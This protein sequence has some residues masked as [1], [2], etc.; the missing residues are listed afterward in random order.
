MLQDSNVSSNVL[1]LIMASWSQGA[2]KQYYTY[3]KRRMDFCI[4]NKVSATDASVEQAIEFLTGLCEKD[5]RFLSYKY[6]KIHVVSDLE[7]CRW[8]DYWKSSPE[9][10]VHEWSFQVKISIAKIH[11]HI[12]GRI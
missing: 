2:K 5:F 11:G 7:A 9:E 6:S 12:Q 4:M 1:Q 3:T 10:K 8:H